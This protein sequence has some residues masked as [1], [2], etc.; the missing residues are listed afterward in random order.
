MFL[1]VHCGWPGSVH[2]TRV[3]RVS[4]LAINAEINEKEMFNG[5]YIIGDQA[6]RISVSL[7]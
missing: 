3:L 5:C 6:Y 4:P 2:D 1:D 7:A